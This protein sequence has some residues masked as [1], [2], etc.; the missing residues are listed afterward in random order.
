MANE[1]DALVKK[2]REENEAFETTENIIICSLNHAFNIKC[3]ECEV[4][5]KCPVKNL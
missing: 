4:K 3:E 5:E 1:I 2:T